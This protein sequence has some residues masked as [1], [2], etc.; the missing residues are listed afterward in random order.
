MD[1]LARDSD[2]FFYVDYISKGQSELDYPEEDY[3]EY[4]SKLREIA[5]SGVQI[6]DRSVAMK[7][8]WLAGKLNTHLTAE[9]AGRSISV[10]AYQRY[11]ATIEH[12]L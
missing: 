6:S 5:A 3:P 10:K 9:G 12:P 8:R 4:L 7:Y 11:L 1:L 2:G